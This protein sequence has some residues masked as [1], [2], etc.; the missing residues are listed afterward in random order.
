MIHS[1]RL[2]AALL[3][4]ATVAAAPP[5]AHP[6]TSPHCSRIGDGLHT[7]EAQR[8]SGGFHRLDQLPSANEYLTVLR[9]EDGCQK[10]VIVRY[11]VDGRASGR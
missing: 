7:A 9:S 11:D 2:I 8:R 10:P 5:S 1:H 6:D 4:A 3:P